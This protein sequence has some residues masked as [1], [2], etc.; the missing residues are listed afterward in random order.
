M[1]APLLI[2]AS[3]VLGQKLEPVR[4]NSMPGKAAQAPPTDFLF[5]SL[6]SI[7]ALYN[8]A[9]VSLSWLTSDI[10]ANVQR[11]VSKQLLKMDGLDVE[12]INEKNEKI[13]K[14]M[15]EMMPKNMGPFGMGS[16]G[17]PV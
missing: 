4:P 15:E 11:V 16:E 3:L 2:F 14:K 8:P 5:P 12:A 9:A 7:A 6:F 13:R 17:A 1:I 10:A